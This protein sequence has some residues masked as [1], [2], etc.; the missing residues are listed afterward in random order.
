MKT[1]LILAVALVGCFALIGGVTWLPKVTAQNYP[2]TLPVAFPNIRYAPMVFTATGQTKT[3]NIGGVS[4][5]SI[6]V[7]G[8]AFT[9]ATWTLVGSNDGGMNW[10]PLNVAPLAVPLAPVTTATTTASVPALYVANLAG[11]TNIEIVTSG[12]FTASAASFQITSTSNT[13]L[14]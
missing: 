7:T 14:L 10:F 12:T 3:Q 8:S 9:T 2:G 5:A 6:S 13:G 11:L 4:A 1:K